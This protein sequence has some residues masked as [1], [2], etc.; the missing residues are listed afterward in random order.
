M[1]K[2]LAWSLP[3][4]RLV[5]LPKSTIHL[6][7]AHFPQNLTAAHSLIQSN[8]PD[9][10]RNGKSM[11]STLS[12]AIL[13]DIL[14]RYTDLPAP[15][16]CLSKRPNGK[17]YLVP[18]A[19]TYDND[20]EFNISHTKE[21]VVVAIADNHVGVDIERSD[22]H[23]NNVDKLLK[24]F[25]PAESL[26]VQSC[27][28]TQQKCFLD[29]WTRKEAF[30]KCVGDGIKRGLNS[31]EVSIDRQT[32]WLEHIDNDYI[33]P[34]RYYTISFSVADVRND[35]SPHVASLVYYGNS[36]QVVKYLWKPKTDRI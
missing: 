9:H 7:K 33:E 8:L 3:P 1:A 30:L 22:R 36:A 32:N 4:P 14:S 34:S 19:L 2:C 13:R 24:R 35:H 20:I 17:P 10:E 21:M 5:S 28:N 25:T 11:T 16:L 27:R 6:W 23:I 15:E 12:R 29:L 26:A 31:F 18:S